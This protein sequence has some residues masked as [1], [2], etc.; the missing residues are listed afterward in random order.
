MC[1]KL[2]CNILVLE[3]FHSY[4]QHCLNYL[5]W[6]WGPQKLL[7]S[8]F[9]K[10]LAIYISKLSFILYLTM[11]SSLYKNKSTIP[12]LG[13]LSGGILP[14]FQPACKLDSTHSY[15]CHGSYPAYLSMLLFTTRPPVVL[16]NVKY[17][18]ISFQMFVFDKFCWPLEVLF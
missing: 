6:T 14:A 11:C 12:V 8:S 18:D 7:S 3:T 4:F 17:C 10:R 2:Q 5:L 15:R 1:I 9:R 13:S 16:P